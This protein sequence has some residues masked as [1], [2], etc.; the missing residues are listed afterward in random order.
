MRMSPYTETKSR[1]EIEICQ[2]RRVQYSRRSRL[3]YKDTDYTRY[4]VTV[5]NRMNNH[6]SISMSN[7]KIMNNIN[8]YILNPVI[9]SGSFNRLGLQFWDLN[10]HYPSQDPSFWETHQKIIQLVP[11]ENSHP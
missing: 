11:D 7:Y 9:Y 8:L 5:N 6:K 1:I 2:D 10:S 3:G 4:T